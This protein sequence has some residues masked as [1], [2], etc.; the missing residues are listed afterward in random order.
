ME[1]I[2]KAVTKEN[3]CLPNLY[4]FLIYLVIAFPVQCGNWVNVSLLL[5]HNTKLK[6]RTAANWKKSIFL[7]NVFV[8][9]VSELSFVKFLKFILK[10]S[11]QLFLKCLLD[12]YYVYIVISSV[13]SWT[14]PVKDAAYITSALQSPQIYFLG[15]STMNNHSVVTWIDPCSAPMIL[16]N[17][18]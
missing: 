16:I 10:R 1:G 15:G 18:L 8:F 9:H 5:K 4:S 11:K 12:V 6:I 14:F 2:T 3:L 13:K 7:N 17:T